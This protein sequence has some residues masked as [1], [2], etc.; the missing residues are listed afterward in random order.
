MERLESLYS[1]KFSNFK[2]LN[3]KSIKFNPK[4]PF[5]FITGKI[6]R[7]RKQKLGPEFETSLTP[8][9]LIKWV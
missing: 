2:T 7:D 6:V 5:M 1:N 8:N 9:E 3:F 4:S